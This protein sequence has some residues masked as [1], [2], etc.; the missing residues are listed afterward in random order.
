MGRITKDG[1]YVFRVNANDFRRPHVHV[2]F[3]GRTVRIDLRTGAFM[4]QPPAGHQGAI[5]AAYRRNLRA[6]LAEFDKFHP[7]DEG[8]DDDN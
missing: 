2:E 1:P 5:R 7:V 8:D 6:I 3:G 4:D